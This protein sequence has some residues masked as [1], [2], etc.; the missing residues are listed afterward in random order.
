MRVEW[1]LEK[2]YVKEVFAAKTRAGIPLPVNPDEDELVISYNCDIAFCNL[3]LDQL[4]VAQEL[5]ASDLIN[6]FQEHYTVWLKF[7]KQNKQYFIDHFQKLRVSEQRRRDKLKHEA[8]K[9]YRRMEANRKKAAELRARAAR[10][11]TQTAATT[12]CT[13][14]PTPNRQTRM[15]E[16]CAAATQVPQT[17]TGDV[18][19]HEAAVPGPAQCEECDGAAEPIVFKIEKRVPAPMHPMM[20]FNTIMMAYGIVILVGI[21][22][23]AVPAA[24]GRS[25]L[26]IH[27]L[28]QPLTTHLQHLSI[29]VALYCQHLVYGVLTMLEYPSP[30]VTVPPATFQQ[31]ARFVCI[32]L[33]TV[34]EYMLGYAVYF[35]LMCLCCAVHVMNLHALN[36]LDGPLSE[37]IPQYFKYFLFQRS[38]AGAKVSLTVLLYLVAAPVAL[39]LLLAQLDHYRSSGIHTTS[40]ESV[41]VA[42]KAITTCIFAAM[43]SCLLV[44]S[45]QVC[46]DFQ[47]ELGPRFQYNSPWSSLAT[48]PSANYYLQL[49]KSFAMVSVVALL[50]LSALIVLPLSAARSIVPAVRHLS[51]TADPGG[52]IVQWLFLLVFT[53]CVVR[54]LLITRSAAWFAHWIRHYFLVPT[55]DVT[56]ARSPGDATAAKQPSWSLQ[57]LAWMYSVTQQ[58][59]KSD[60]LS[61]F[62]AIVLGMALLA[63]LCVLLLVHPLVAATYFMRH[64]DAH[65]DRALPDHS[66]RVFV[67]Y[68]AGCIVTWIFAYTARFLVQDITCSALSVVNVCRVMRRAGWMA[69]KLLSVVLLWVGVPPLLVGTLLHELVMMPPG[70][71]LRNTIV[72]PSVGM[73]LNATL[74]RHGFLIITTM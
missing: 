56:A 40:Q 39:V 60:I 31:V 63:A 59:H 37:M 22:L 46:E 11:A 38:P 72:P 66:M 69:V 67:Y 24:V 54:K 29:T 34:V 51:H 9:R 44:Y 68:P 50:L 74:W 42:Y 5:G 73:L 2:G 32:K 19:T 65:T 55:R 30:Q 71:G 3:A 7:L 61:V 10:V 70:Y 8:N 43:A 21:A 15:S 57:A 58:A 48:I 12:V 6:G 33:R 26:F 49:L 35:A 16:E 62:I 52:R 53:R 23:M 17:T 20:V 36:R 27:V 1:E 41:E 47:R 4:R 14:M 45:Q 28:N 13:E 18:V 25:I 64:L